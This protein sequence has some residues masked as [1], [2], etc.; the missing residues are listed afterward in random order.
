MKFAIVGTGGT[1][2]SIGAYLALAG[3]DVTFIARGKHL[4]AI[5]EKGL[6]L[7]TSHRGDILI[8]PAKAVT[9][10]EY[11]DTPDVMFVCVKYYNID[12][13][14]AF[15]KRRAGTDTLIVPILNVFGTGDVMQQRLPGLTCLD[16]CMYIFARILEPGVILQPDKLLRIIFGFR[17]GQDT[18]LLQKAE[19]LERVLRA[20]DI[21]GHFSQ[22]IQRDALKKFALVSPFGAASLYLNAISDDFQ[23]EGPERDMFMGLIKEVVA[24]GN[25]MGITFED[26]LLEIGLKMMDAF[27]PGMTTSMH[28]DVS[29]GRPSEFDGWVTR[30][31]DLGKQYGVPVPLY[32]KVLEWGREHN[33]TNQ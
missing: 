12:D 9:M 22:N 19:E 8:R 6:T 20:A 2:G 5:R 29:A 30:M 4:E 26:D 32:T 14:I 18:R 11:N 31:V 28:R 7:R 13:A 3:N 1:G 25:A 21:K 23:K 15:T 10:E 16:G 17:P 33:V 24:V 27:K